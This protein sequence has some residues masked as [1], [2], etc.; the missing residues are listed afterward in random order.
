MICLAV[1]SPFR[2]SEQGTLS[3]FNQSRDT[4]GMI[5]PIPTFKQHPMKPW[6]S[7]FR[8]HLVNKGKVAY[9]TKDYLHYI[10]IHNSS[11]YGLAV[12]SRGKKK[13]KTND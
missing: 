7:V 4:I 2:K 13:R 12:T 8:K 3:G 6:R 9:Q 11:E 10:L 5:L 1:F